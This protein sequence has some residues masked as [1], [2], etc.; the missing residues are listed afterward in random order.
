MFPWRKA[1]GFGTAAG[2]AA[3]S[4]AAVGEGGARSGSFSFVAGHS[5]LG[6]SCQVSA[7]RL[8]LVAG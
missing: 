4:R 3:A 1:L 7:A 2:I 8:Q 6:V 5:S